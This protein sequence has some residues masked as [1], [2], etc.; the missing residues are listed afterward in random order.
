M[1]ITIIPLR[2][3]IRTITEMIFFTLLSVNALAVP[4]LLFSDLESAP[5]NGWSHANEPDKG[6]AVTIWGYGFGESREQSYVSVNGVDLKANTDYAVWGEYWPTPFYQRITFWLNDQMSDGEGEITLTVNGEQSNLLPFT[7]REGRIFFIESDNASGYGT[8][9]QPFDFSDA[10]TGAAWLTNMQAGD[11]YYFKDSAIYTEKVN[12][13]N[14]HV[15]LRATDIS[16]TADKP[17]AFLAYP[18]QKPFFK[19]PTP[20]S[21]NFRLGFYMNNDYSVLSGLSFDSPEIATNVSGNYHRVIGNDFKASSGSYTMGT[22]IVN[23]FGDGH[24]LLGNN[25]HGMRSGSR[26]DHG[27]YLSGCSPNEGVKF[28]WNYLHDNDFGRGPVISVNHQG[29]RCATD[30]T[31]KAHFIFNNIVDC[32][33]QRSTAVG[34]Y[35]LSYDIGEPEPEPTYVYNN[36]IVNCGT[37]DPTDNHVQWTPT[38]YHANG[39]ARFYH[40]TLFNSGY[41]GFQTSDSA[42]VLSTHFKN[43]IVHMNP[44][45]PSDLGSFYIHTGLYDSHPNKNYFSYNFY[46]GLDEYDACGDCVDESNNIIGQDPLFINPDNFNFEL[47]ADS[48]AIDMATNNLVFEVAPPA[49]APIHRDLSHLFRVGQF[50]MGALE[51]RSGFAYTIGGEISG[52]AAGKQLVLQNN[53]GDDLVIS[54]NSYFEFPTLMTGGNPYDVTVLTQPEGQIC[55]VQAADGTIVDSDIH[56]VMIH[57]IDTTPSV[58]TTPIVLYSDLESAPKNGWSIAEPNKGAAVTIWGTGFGDTRGDSYVLVNDVIL[59]QDTDFAVWGEYWPTPQHQRITFWLNDQMAD[60]LV[61]IAVIVNGQTSEPISFTI[62]SGR[63]FFIESDNPN[64]DGSVENPFDFSD[65]ARN[66]SWLT[67][68][69]QGD[70]FYFKDS[71]VYTERANGGNSHLWLRTTNASGTAQQPI[72]FLAYPNQKPVFQV[73]SPYT[74]NFRKATDMSTSHAVLSG[75]TVDSPGYAADINGSYHRVVGNDFKASSG[76]YTQGTGIINVRGDGHKVFGN[77]LHGMRSGK[78]NDRGI[79]V[80]GC[81]PNEG[82]KIGWNY[83]HD[84]DFGKGGEISV[85]HVNTLCESSEIVQSHFIFSNVIH[86]DLQ[87]AKA[88][89]IYD[90]SYDLGELEPQPTYVY[91]NLIVGCGTYDSTDNQVLSAPALEHVNGHARFYNNTLYDAGYIGFYAHENN[92]LLSSEFKNNIVHM[93]PDYPRSNGFTAYV[94]AASSTRLSNNLYFGLGEYES[95]TDCVADQNNISNAD[96]LFVDPDSNIFELQAT[97]PA[98]NGGTR[99]LNFEQSIY[100]APINRDIHGTFRTGVFDIGAFDFDGTP[101][102]NVGGTLTGLADDAFIEVQV[103]SSESFMLDKNGYFTLEIPILDGQAYAVTIVTQPALPQQVCTIVEGSGFIAGVDVTNIGINCVSADLDTDS[104]GIPNIW[105]Q[106]PNVA[107]DNSCSGDHV[108]VQGTFLTGTQTSCHATHLITVETGTVVQT[109]AFLALVAPQI[110]V[111]SGFINDGKVNMLMQ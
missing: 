5:K 60:G 73:A 111:N 105:D 1:K 41:L 59:D 63:I 18:N 11:V 48:P 25:L 54:H 34:I 96:P 40:N 108:I 10:T 101:A 37:Y 87:R 16:G 85:Y 26:F 98:V 46:F 104:D 32:S 92:L 8:V 103:N 49:Y 106:T 75:L 13:G 94:D 66:T 77:N 76:Q 17:I 9:E 27:I 68:M 24:V 65:A 23:T 102:Y 20:R 67:H 22:G 3:C 7:I 74:V 4:V 91:N 12:G 55:T 61:E 82:A 62:R 58:S 45:F 2:K 79:Y 50:D 95:C 81:S 88:I 21:V 33:L 42:S 107:N 90:L 14:A 86:C 100:D 19:V 83:L 99:D 47:Q 89:S 93:S 110:I 56:N 36:L 57:C 70:I 35:D 6:A 28:G 52:L 51:F 71:A 84:N 39:H 15:W 31:L 97:S 109:D 69:E 43:N 44:N 30:E 29:D 64:G 38:M 72:A 53:M 78:S 80:K